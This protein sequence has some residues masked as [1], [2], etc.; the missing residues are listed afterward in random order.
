MKQFEILY[1]KKWKIF[2]VFSISIYLFGVSI[3]KCIIT[4]NALSKLFNGVDVLGAF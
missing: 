1:G 2:P 4:G 3:S